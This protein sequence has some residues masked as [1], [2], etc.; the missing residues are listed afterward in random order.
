MN[1]EQRSRLEQALI[2][3]GVEGF[4]RGFSAAV[5]IVRDFMTDMA[6]VRMIA[7]ET[8]IDIDGVIKIIVLVAAGLDAGRNAATETANQ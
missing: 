4:D 3:T 6:V 7:G 2:E 5:E 8:G 1:D